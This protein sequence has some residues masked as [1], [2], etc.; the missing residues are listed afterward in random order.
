LVPR[1]VTPTFIDLLSDPVGYPEYGK[2]FFNSFVANKAKLVDFPI[3]ALPGSEWYPFNLGQ[4][5]GKTVWTLR[6]SF[7]GMSVDWA[8]KTGTRIKL[9]LNKMVGGSQ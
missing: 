6:S 4:E 3:E 7:N 8:D 2:N 1:G 5:N 9:D